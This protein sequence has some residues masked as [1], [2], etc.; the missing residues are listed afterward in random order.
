LSDLAGDPL[1]SASLQAIL[2]MRKF[3]RRADR[4]LR[5]GARRPKQSGPLPE[6]D[7]E[8]AVILVNWAATA[9]KDARLSRR[10][11]H[12]GTALEPHTSRRPSDEFD[13][14]QRRQRMGSAAAPGRLAGDPHRRL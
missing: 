10:S 1:N 6:A 14:Q 9:I 13:L 2:P 7:E 5:R 4:A 12:H 8:A 3:L 11:E